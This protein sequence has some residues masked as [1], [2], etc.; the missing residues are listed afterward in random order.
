[1]RKM[2]VEQWKAFV[3]NVIRGEAFTR[4]RIHCT[5]DRKTCHL[6]YESQST[7][8]NF[9]Q[10]W[11]GSYSKPEQECLISKLTSKRNITLIFGV[12]FAKGKMKPLTIFLHVT[13]VYSAPQLYRVRI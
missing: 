2:S 11:Q 4:L 13:V 6:Y 9:N 10:I 3:N 1:M 7:Q 12:P 5:N 8:R